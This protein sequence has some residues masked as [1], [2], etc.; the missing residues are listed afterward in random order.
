MASDGGTRSRLQCILWHQRRLRGLCMYSV[1]SLHQF[2]CFISNKWNTFNSLNLSQGCALIY[3]WILINIWKYINICYTIVD[4][5][6]ILKWLNVRTWQL[7]HA[8]NNKLWPQSGN[9]VSTSLGNSGL[10]WTV[11]A[12]NRDSAVPAE[13]SGNLQICILVARSRHVPHCWIR[14]PDETEW[15]LISAALFCGWPV[16]VHDT[17]TRRRILPVLWKLSGDCMRMLTNLLEFQIPQWWWNWNVIWNLYP[18]PD[19]HQ[20]LTSSSNW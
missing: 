3:Y 20:K 13:E 15:R 9:Q 10:C 7:L 1:N 5:E 19:H 12:R 2:S 14:S 4:V 18:G 17:H 8:F 16:M 6:E 11:F